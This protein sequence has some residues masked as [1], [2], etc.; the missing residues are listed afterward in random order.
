MSREEAYGG[1]GAAIYAWMI[2]PMLRKLRRRVSRLCVASGVR[3]VL[4]IACAT[5]AQCRSLQAAGL[6]VTGVDLSEP[7]LAAA[8]QR[9]CSDIQY[10]QASALALPFGDGDFDAAILSLAL[11][12]HPEHER[13]GMLREAMRVTRPEGLLLLADYGRPRFA[14]VH[15]AWLAIRLIERAAGGEHAAGFAE[16]MARGGLDGFARRAGV[17]VRSRRSS[18]GGAIAIVAG[19]A[20]STV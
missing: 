17:Q 15:P 5:G 11:H 13:I 19:A 20:D 8:R 9:S 14:A 1:R 4:D 7:M 18:H 10:M 16:F 12:E 2:D 6:S 3:A